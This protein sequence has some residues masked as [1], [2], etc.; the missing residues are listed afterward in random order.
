VFNRVLADV[1][2]SKP[3]LVRGHYELPAPMGKT[4]GAV[5]VTDMLGEDVFISREI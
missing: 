5:K 4:T 2:G 1:P 3:E